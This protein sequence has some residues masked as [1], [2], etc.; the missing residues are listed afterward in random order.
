M[1]PAS[2][3]LQIV[4]FDLAEISNPTTLSIL[5]ILTSGYV[6]LALSVRGTQWSTASGNERLL[7]GVVF[8]AL[9]GIVVYFVLGA[10]QLSLGWFWDSSAYIESVAVVCV[11]TL[12]LPPLWLLHAA[13]R[14]LVIRRILYLISTTIALLTLG[15]FFSY[16]AAS[17]V[18]ENIYQANVTT[19]LWPLFQSM[20]NDWLIAL[21][22]TGT[23]AYVYYKLIYRE[24]SQGGT[25]YWVVMSPRIGSLAKIFSR[26]GRL[27]RN[28]LGK[29]IATVVIGGIMIGSVS[30]YANLTVDYFTPS[31][32]MDTQS[33]LINVPFSN[34]TYLVEINGTNNYLY[35]KSWSFPC[36]FTVYQAFNE[37]V[38]IHTP[39]TFAYSSN[40]VS[41]VL[42]PTVTP[43]PSRQQFSSDQSQPWLQMKII[44]PSH[45]GI[46]DESTNVRWFDIGF[47][48]ETRDAKVSF[49]FVY[50]NTA[51]VPE[52]SCTDSGTVEF[53]T[54]GGLI[55]QHHF[56]VV[57]NGDKVVLIDMIRLRELLGP[58][59][60]NST[61]IYL[62]G[63][64]MNPDFFRGLGGYD[65]FG[66]YTL[67]PLTHGQGFN[68]TSNMTV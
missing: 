63:K 53:P 51:N 55:V 1:F 67:S 32:S 37:T 48:N 58:I 6:F 19:F 24:L 59:V 41:L 9:Y 66:F 29:I 18:I 11:A 33:Q 49:S 5:V 7:S 22:C 36:L 57:N 65:A 68:F 4:P 61:Q 20:S 45:L 16:F 39:K 13:Q 54:G 62:N 64:A 28:R 30:A 47:G 2:V 46:T 42:P 17:I 56:V 43:F 50:Y 10:I 15:L 34:A 26:L 35:N 3:G 8:G 38:T 21:I 31:V 14:Q 60:A 12:V 23:F 44:N 25:I 52:I 40:N 27:D